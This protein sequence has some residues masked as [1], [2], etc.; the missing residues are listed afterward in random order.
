MDYIT[1]LAFRQFEVL[2]ASPG[3][4]WSFQAIEY[5]CLIGLFH[6]SQCSLSVL[7]ISIPI[8]DIFLNASIARDAFKALSLEQG[9]VPFLEQLYITDTPIHMEN[10]GLLEDAGG[11]HEMFLSRLDGDGRL[12]TLHLSLKI[13]WSLQP[14]TLPVPQDSPFCDLFRIKDQGMD[15]Q[16]FFD[17]KDCLVGEEAG[18]SFFGSS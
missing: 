5:T 12:D 10:S 2:A 14:L 4:P 17:M 3:V 15:V 8:L 6:R 7:T 1:L 13:D 16:F 9:A 11:F 18:A